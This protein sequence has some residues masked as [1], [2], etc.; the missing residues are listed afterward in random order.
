MGVPD[1]YDAIS[2][3][4]LIWRVIAAVG[5]IFLMV[6]LIDAASVW[7]PPALGEPEWELGTTS[8][9]F[10]TFS[11]LGLGLALLVGAAVARGRTWQARGLATLCILVAVFMWLALALYLTVLPLVLS[12]VNDPVALTPIKKAAAK[13]GVQALIYPFAF[14]WLAGAGWRASLKRRPTA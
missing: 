6:G 4:Q 5:L 10:D 2:Q 14:L 1:R 13:T 11:L 3:D 12:R 9:F 7:L 8:Q